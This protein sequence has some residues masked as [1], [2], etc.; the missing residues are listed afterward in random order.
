MSDVLKEAV[1]AEVGVGWLK[2]PVLVVGVL[3]YFC[4][5]HRCCF[6]VLLMYA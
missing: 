1:T 6:E 4:P 3:V 5:C 2:G